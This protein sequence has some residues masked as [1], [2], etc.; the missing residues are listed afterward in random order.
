MAAANVHS[1]VGP[2]FGLILMM[3]W[4]TSWAS[5]W[6][7]NVRPIMTVPYGADEAVRFQGNTTSKD[8]FRL[9]QSDGEFV[10][11]GARK[12]GMEKMASISDVGSPVKR[13]KEMEARVCH[14]RK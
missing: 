4:S 6:Q 12:R 2:M 10:L 11:V 9:L 1:S 14:Y 13:R 7:E 8:H 3:A 5:S